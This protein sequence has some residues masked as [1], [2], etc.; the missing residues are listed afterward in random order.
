MAAMELRLLLAWA[1][2]GLIVASSYGT[3]RLP[4]WVRV[5]A[6]VIFLAALS[7]ALMPLVGSP[8]DPHFPE[9]AGR[10][11]VQATK[12]LMAIWWL[13]VARVVIAGGR[14]AIDRRQRAMHF[15]SDLAA[16]AVYLAAA[17]AILD[18]VFGVSVMGLVATSGIIAIVLGLALQS[19]LS[20]LFS[21]VAIGIDRPFKVGDVVSLDGTI[22][23]RIVETSWRSMR[24]VTATDAV[25]TVPNSIVAKSRVLNKT[26]PTDNQTGTVRFVID[27]TVPPA[28]AIA[29][30]RGAYFSAFPLSVSADP[31][32]VCTELK[33]DGAAYQITFAAPLATFETVRSELF[34]QVARHLRYAGMSLAPQ[35]A[36]LPRTAFDAL[37][38]L[39]DVPLM[40]ALADDE[41]TELASGV[42]LRTGHTGATIFDQ[43]G[44]LA[45]L[46]VIA[47][48]AFEV[49]RDDGTGARR[50][51]TIGPGDYFGELALLTGLP[52][53]ATVR[54]LTPFAVYEVGKATI[55]P[56]MARNPALL[57]ALEEAAA[58]AQALLDRTIAAH[59]TMDVQAGVPLLQRIRDFFDLR[60]DVRV[61]VALPPGRT[62]AGP[63]SSD[64]RN[65]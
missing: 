43:G 33:G 52:N 26:S 64:A 31:A 48:G 9:P 42:C 17:L 59:A 54:A 44:S 65:A 32:V 2:V 18:M 4:G 39:R 37:R 6:S 20:D 5:A 36:A 11:E 58:A 62:G 23:G 45:A 19:T 63:A 15:A 14:F 50:L 46:F 28:D 8:L 51:G 57:Q 47:R 25:A 53:T 38:S 13:L 21:G 41:L 34:H 10:V 61:R 24:L 3:R 35:M 12:V 30:L 7:F 49:V 27:P 22:D 29:V 55:A 56:L 60:S 1:L 40:M 16:G